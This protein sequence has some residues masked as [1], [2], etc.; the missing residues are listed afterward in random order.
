MRLISRFA[1]LRIDVVAVSRAQ[2]EGSRAEIDGESG[3]IK[4]DETL[5]LPEVVEVLAH[6]MGHLLLHGRL[7]DRMVPLD[8]V[9]ASA[10]A[11]TGA[12]AIARYSPR[13][14]EEVEANAF[15][16]EFSCP[17]DELFA[18]WRADQDV[19]IAKLADRFSVPAQVVRVQLANALYEVAIGGDARGGRRMRI[20]QLTLTEDQRRAAQSIGK[21]VLVDAGAGTGKTATL[22][23][24]VEFLIQE[25]GVRP[26]EIL[27]VTFSNE[28]AEELTNRIA[29]RFGA[30]TANAVTVSTFHGLGMEFLQ[31]HGN[32]LGYDEDPT[33]L[34]EDSQAELIYEM[35]GRVPC[36]EPALLRDPWGTAVR[37]VEHI[38][39]CK[40]WLITPE[41]LG[42][43]IQNDAS[44]APA[45]LELV[46]IYREYER[47]K[48]AAGRVDFADLI[49]LPLRA[50]EEQDAVRDAWRTRFPWVMVDEF[51]DV[52]RA[53]SSFLRALC[54]PNNPPW[55]VGD[56]RQ[57]IYRFLGASPENISNFRMHFPDA[58]IFS[59]EVNYRSSEPV[60]GAAN[61]LAD[62]LAMP[63][64]GLQT[65]HSWRCGSDIDP[66]GSEPIA[67]AEA[68]SDYAERAGIVEQVRAWLCDEGVMA[69]DIAILARRHIDVRNTMLGLKEAG[70]KA[71]AAGLLTA[72]GPAGDL[73]GALMIADAP[74][75]AFPRLAY[76]LG[77]ES[78]TPDAINELAR[79]MFA[80]EET[81]G[82]LREQIASVQIKAEEEKFSGDGW[83]ALTSFLFESSSYLKRVLNAADTAERAVALIEIVST[84]SLAAAYRATHPN[85][86]PRKA[87]IGFA[88][89]LRT[90]LTETIPLP[91]MP[92]PRADVVRVMTCH[93]AKGLEFGCVVVAG[94]T[95]P[96]MPL[97]YPWLPS[98]LRPA[99]SEDD[100]Q[101]NSLLF[102]GVTRAKRTVV[103]S[104]PTHA[105]QGPRARDKKM[106]PLLESWRQQRKLRVHVWNEYGA[107][108][109]MAAGRP[110]WGFPARGTLKASALGDSVCP[111]LTYLEN[112]LGMRFPE[113][114]VALYPRFFAAIRRS[115]RQVVIL[116]DQTR[117]RVTEAQADA[118]LDVEWPID[119]FGDHPHFDLYRSEALRITRGFAAAFTPGAVGSAILEPELEVVGDTRGPKLI[120]DLV[121]Y[122]REPS[123]RVV[124][125]AFRPESYAAKA[126]DT[127]LAWSVLTDIKRASF[128]LT[129]ANVGSTT[130]ILYSGADRAMYNYSLQSR[131]RKED[132]LR[133][134]AGSLA[135]RYRA[136]STGD[137][138]TTVN[139]FHCDQCRARVSCPHWLGAL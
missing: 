23:G 124:A 131:N 3:V 109:A 106:V 139:P 127:G 82:P 128:V 105:G 102:V 114:E 52:S 19:T 9:L 101:A 74:Q 96:R 41:M 49:M 81:R 134:E 116:A 58:K 94:Q 61:D 42:E 1:D 37:F 132:S 59:L 115:L 80:G 16:L 138:T 118:I 89:R 87:R 86:P 56:A 18:T 10:Y 50:L 92:K 60:V 26:E 120:L 15:A 69:G 77:R 76:A 4:Y 68:T 31:L 17:T 126:K 39:H 14:R 30:E 28:A 113:E 7:T 57:A 11:D 110:V 100:E 133:R 53:T 84:L 121:A 21:P 67:L 27:V 91:L 63:P 64:A 48:F 44:V 62:L 122:F 99:S 5:R 125:I 72:E 119:R 2:M 33:L 95:V 51:Q 54:G 108:D 135:E 35:L 97:R 45:G 112:I 34:D 47:A 71:Q 117:T 78:E 32:S 70:I 43:A 88:E 46:A 12:A 104:W 73:A 6:E 103:V 111:L 25:K 90:R 79:R 40:H 22:I 66:L 107:D 137:F 130:A 65:R 83:V 123:G 98:S 93:A 13:V 20:G 55:V 8:P 36:S 24:R 38:N 29:D 129:E 85:T 136:L 75:A